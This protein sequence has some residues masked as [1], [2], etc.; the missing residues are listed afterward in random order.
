MLNIVIGVAL[1]IVTLILLGV[2]LRRISHWQHWPAVLGFVKSA[3]SEDG[4]PSSSRI[5]SAWLSLASMALISWSIRHAMKLNG[6]DAMVWVGG[7]P[8]IIYALGAFTIAPYSVCKLG[9][10]AAKI[11]GKGG[12]IPPAVVDAPVQAQSTTVI[13]DDQQKG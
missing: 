9:S 6:Q 12:A 11:W 10:S 3:F 7:L 13:V 8:Q 1:S 4:S 5:I 2:L